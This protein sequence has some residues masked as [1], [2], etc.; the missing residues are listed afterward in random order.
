MSGGHSHSHSHGAY[1]NRDA[2]RAVVVSAIALGLASTI[3]FIAAIA[4]GSAG[5]LADAL[6]GG[7]VLLPAGLLRHMLPWSRAILSSEPP[8]PWNPLMWD[9]IAQ[10]YPW[11]HYAAEWVA[12]DRFPLWNP[13]QF[14]GT[15]FFANS[16]S[17][18]FY[19]INALFY[20]PGPLS[21]AR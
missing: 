9:G 16:Q 10:F 5:V 15:P 13:H 2:V 18:L 19:P 12:R 1:D 6:F 17:A 14:C 4:S 3:E 8:P 20:L 21:T 11:R 7:R